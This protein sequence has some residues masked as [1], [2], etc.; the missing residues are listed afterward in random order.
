MR[1]KL[2]KSETEKQRTRATYPVGSV[3]PSRRGTTDWSIKL[4]VA[5][6]CTREAT[7]PA[8]ADLPSSS[9]SSS[10]SSSSSSAPCNKN[11]ATTHRPSDCGSWLLPPVSPWPPFSAYLPCTC[12]ATATPPILGPFSLPFIIRLLLFPPS[13]SSPPAAFWL[14]SNRLCTRSSDP[15]GY[16]ISGASCGHSKKS[17]PFPASTFPI[18]LF[19]SAFIPTKHLPDFFFF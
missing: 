17:L 15:H 3:N 19:F 5:S 10:N 1:L 2:D 11:W 13:S 9:N 4:P 6:G 14:P 16:H 12:H 18:P 8:A 7:A